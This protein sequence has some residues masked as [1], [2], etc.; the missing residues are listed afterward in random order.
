M[1]ITPLGYY[2]LREGP[3]MKDYVQKAL[4]I[5]SRSFSDNECRSIGAILLENGWITEDTLRLCLFRQREDCLREI[6]LFESVPADTLSSIA[7]LSHHVVLPEGSVVFRQ[8]DKADSYFLIISGNVVVSRSADTK[9]EVPVAQ[10]GPGQGFG[11]I[12]LL[13]GGVRTATVTTATK[14]VLISLPKQ[15]F[16]FVL[17]TDTILYRT[18]INVLAE[19]LLQGNERIA[20]VH[21]DEQAYR[22][23][24][25]EQAEKHDPRLAGGSPIIRKIFVE[26]DKAASHKKPILVQGET[27]TELWDV[28]ALIHRKQFGSTGLFTFDSKR[29]GCAGYGDE[30][31]RPGSLAVEVTQTSALFGRSR[32][33]LPFAGGKRI[34]LV[35]L[36]SEGTVVIEHVDALSPAVQEKLAD[37]IDTGKFVPLGEKSELSSNARIICTTN[38]DPLVL[39]DQGLFSKRLADL[40]RGAVISLPPLR[41]RK[42]DLRD[43]TGNL[44]ESNSRQLGRSVQSID[45]DAYKA[46]MAYDWPGNADELNAVIRRAI[47]LS[48]DSVLKAEHIFISPPPVTGQ[49]AF[50]LFRVE[51]IKKLFL[52][53]KFPVAVQ[54]SVAPFIALTILLGLFGT[55]VPGKNSVLVLT[56]GYWEPFVVIGS[57]FFARAW[58][59]ACPLGPFGYFVGKSFGL[60]KK[61][62]KIVRKYGI[63]FTAAGIA[64]IFWSESSAGMLSSPHATSMLVLVIAMFAISV[65]YLYERRTWC[66]YLCPLG[67]LVGFLSSCSL[68]EL[69]SNYNICN[70]SCM[71]HDCYVGNEEIEGCPLFEGPFSLRSNNNCVLCGNCIKICPHN[72]PVLNLRIPGQ[73]IWSSL[74]LERSAVVI[75]TVLLGTQL[76]RGLEK[77][78]IFHGLM[79]G[80]SWW[81][82]AALLIAGII[83]GV[84][85]FSF[86][87]G[88]RC[89][90]LDEMPDRG[91]SLIIYCLIPLS[92]AF[93]MNFHLARLLT[94]GGTLPTVLGRQ[95]GLETALPSFV[96]VPSAIKILQVII[97]LAGL[98][99]SMKIG[100]KFSR[101]YNS[102]KKT[103]RIP[104]LFFASLY[105]LL[106]LAV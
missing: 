69:R 4:D 40:L 79:S 41:K 55:Q 13:T 60:K 93:E 62:P 104:V 54:A 78:G 36:S 92:V 38:S 15:S 20:Q 12:A 74:K 73:E 81:L 32:D 87:S 24:I 72:S 56:W 85:A 34:G 88:R 77:L 89:F 37:F 1:K 94:I 49:I 51:K 98:A 6:E 18:F 22:D 80:G 19:R 86:V 71:K 50:E 46:I 3:D 10:L 30:E 43:I 57:F 47:S 63:Y 44:I 83:L 39:S 27:G 91:M 52:T 105:L 53:K 68:V 101:C 16:D 95:I 21:V 7:Q 97:L 14:T 99:G 66:R 84:I 82:S 75:G 26:I 102:G 28:A 103:V 96:A 8:Y 25:S 100:A 23:F 35:H 90:P 5:Q 70:T 11:E 106:F 64:V 2:L 65:G 45:E 17:A 61:V 67:G 58:C 9:E 29:T 33:V 59:S 48:S 76:F 42:K 31:G